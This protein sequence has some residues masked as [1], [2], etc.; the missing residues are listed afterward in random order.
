MFVPD[1]HLRSEKCYGIILIGYPYDEI[2]TFKFR[3]DL[4][5]NKYNNIWT[6]CFIK[7]REMGKFV[8]T[9]F[10]RDSKMLPVWAMKNI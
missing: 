9:G 6:I 2:Y 8:C 1:L 7:Y 4:H 5:V 3:A 10:E